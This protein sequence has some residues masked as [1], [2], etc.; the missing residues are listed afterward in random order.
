MKMF[1]FEDGT[2]LCIP[3]EIFSEIASF[4][5]LHNKTAESGGI[6]LGKKQKGSEIYELSR[7]SSP[8]MGDKRSRFGFI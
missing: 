6:L 2:S 8:Q 3:E 4:R 7:I 5:Q 1:I